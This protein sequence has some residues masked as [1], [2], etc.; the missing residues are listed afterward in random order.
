LFL[1]TLGDALTNLRMKKLWKNRT[2][3]SND[4]N[5]VLVV[6]VLVVSLSITTSLLT[7]QVIKKKMWKEE[8]CALCRVA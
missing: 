7:R 4:G 6:I 5:I 2:L 3:D 1:E 8:K